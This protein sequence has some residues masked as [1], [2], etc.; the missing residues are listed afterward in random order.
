MFSRLFSLFVGLLLISYASA[1]PTLSERIDAALRKKN[2]DYDK[3]AARGADDAEFLRRV[4]LDLTGMIP[5]AEAAREFFADK[6]DDR[7][8]RS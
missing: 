7:R 2:P 5:S 3:Q 4:S 8:A 1:E 6:S